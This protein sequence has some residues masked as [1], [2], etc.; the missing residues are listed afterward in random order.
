MGWFAVVFGMAIHRAAQ[1]D[2]LLQAAAD[3]W[4]R[5]TPGAELLLMT[6]GDDPRPDNAVA[7]RTDGNVTVHVHRCTDCRA[8]HC[9]S[10]E[11]AA[12]NSSCSGVR[13][14]WLARRKVLHLLVAM[15]QRY[16]TP[17]PKHAFLKLDPDTLPLPHNLMRLLSELHTALGSAQP[18]LFGMAAC[19]VP[20]FPLCHA[21]GGAGYG[22]SRPALDALRKYVGAHYPRFLERVDRFTYGGED[23][24]VA[25]A[26]K[27][28]A[29]ISVINVGCMYQHR[30]DT[31]AH[32]HAHGEQWVHWPL[33]TT[34]ISFHKFKDDDHLRRAFAC[35]L[36]N[37]RGLPRPAPRSLFSPAALPEPNRT[38]ADAD[39]ACARASTHAA[40]SSAEVVADAVVGTGSAGEASGAWLDLRDPS[41]RAS[42]T[43]TTVGGAAGSV[44]KQASTSMPPDR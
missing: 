23:V 3:T 8:M 17:S 7:P 6:D 18:Y 31:Y 38:A 10:L 4:L 34:P 36:Y 15:G 30:P 27:K 24:A 32:L 16:A 25:F 42:V 12:P 19:R 39:A 41:A 21:S 26:L 22:L 44:G 5:M 20:S 40:V 35:A 33:S 2:A 9:S 11:A 28:Q 29:G 1:I 37:A 14:G 43:W 13:E